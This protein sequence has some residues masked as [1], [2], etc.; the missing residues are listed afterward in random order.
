MGGV[1]DGFPAGMRVDMADV[2]RE[3]D[4]RRPGNAPLTSSRREPDEVEFLSGLSGDGVTLGTPI[5]FIIR[6]RDARPADY[7]ALAGKYRPNHA[8]YAWQQRYGVMP[9]SGGGRASARETVSRVV[10][11]ALAAQFLALRGVAVHAW[12]AAVGGVEGSMEQMMA[13]VEQARR[14][15]DSVGALVRGE[16]TGLPPGFGD[17]VYGKVTSRLA[18]AMMS[19][20]AAKGFEY[21]LGMEAAR[22]S[23]AATADIFTRDPATGHVA[24][25]TNYSGG[26]QGGITNGMPV[27]F[28]VA[29][30]PTPTIPRPLPTVDSD[31]RPC[32]VEGTGR[33][34]PCVGLRAV[35]VVKAMAA[36]VAADLLIN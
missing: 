35:P 34:D 21:G 30:K 8:D 1:L 31:G 20:N 12:L 16:I 23:G 3:L 24:T 13:R 36:L 7:E 6:N 2:R 33:H 10:A 26:L 32:T 28:A 27:T 17:P 18:E 14:E 29:F 22:S 15:H 4:A 19:I 5:A 25:A 11:G 9:G